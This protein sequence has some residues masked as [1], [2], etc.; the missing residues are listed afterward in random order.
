[1]NDVSEVL[2]TATIKEL[3]AVKL[4]LSHYT[5]RRACRGEELWLLLILDLGTRWW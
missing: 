5:P 2:T 4:K 1:L 3:V